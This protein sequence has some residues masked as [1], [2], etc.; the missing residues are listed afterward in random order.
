MFFFW[1]YVFFF[2]KNMT[3]HADPWLDWTNYREIKNKGA[4]TCNSVQDCSTSMSDIF[5]AKLIWVGISSLICRRKPTQ[6]CFRKNFSCVKRILLQSQIVINW[7][8]F[9]NRSYFSPVKSQYSPGQRRMLL[10]KPKKEL[11]ERMSQLPLSKLEL[12]L[13]RL[14]F[15]FNSTY[16]ITFRGWLAR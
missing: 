9:Q 14:R 10:R 8:R 11:R 1:I 13:L 6:N 16:Q 15:H 7:S 2:P 3:D 4:G 12:K 5:R